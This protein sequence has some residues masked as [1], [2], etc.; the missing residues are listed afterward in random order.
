MKTLDNCI[1]AIEDDSNAATYKF[2]ILFLMIIFLNP[3][4]SINCIVGY[5][6]RKNNSKYK[7]LR[8][9]PWEL[10]SIKKLETIILYLHWKLST[11]INTMSEYSVISPVVQDDV[12]MLC[13]FFQYIKYQG[14]VY[15]LGED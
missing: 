5:Q 2:N 15:A 7:L 14:T 13:I 10:N 12:K 9:L 3:C 11:D 1:P 6:T 8:T 4:T